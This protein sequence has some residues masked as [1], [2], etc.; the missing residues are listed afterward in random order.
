MHNAR[1]FNVYYTIE[2]TVT[3][4]LLK[5]VMQ[6]FFSGPTTRQFEIF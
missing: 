2:R 6:L 4:I 1:S 5:Q 3:R